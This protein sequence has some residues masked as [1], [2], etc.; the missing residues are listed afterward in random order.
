MPHAISGSLAY[1]NGMDGFT[2][3]F[4]PGKLQVKDNVAIDNARFNFLFRKGPYVKDVTEQGSFEGNV[5]LRT[6]EGRYADVVNGT[7]AADNVFMA[8]TKSNSAQL[9]YRVKHHE[10]KPQAQDNAVPPRKADGSLARSF[11]YERQ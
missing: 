11:F 9:G 4:N 1:R 8:D 7:I 5:S 3:N 10:R 2:D 6:T